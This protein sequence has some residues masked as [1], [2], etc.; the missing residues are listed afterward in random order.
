MLP[1]PARSHLAAA[2]PGPVPPVLRR[3]LTVRRNLPKT[4]QAELK[5]LRCE[6]LPGTFMLADEAIKNLINSGVDTSR[7]LE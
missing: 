5:G 7:C 1:K 4:R 2:V 3:R 6:A